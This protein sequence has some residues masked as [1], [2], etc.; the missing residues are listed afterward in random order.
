MEQETFYRLR[1]QDKII[2]QMRVKAEQVFFSKDGFWWRGDEQLH[3]QVKKGL[4]TMDDFS[5]LKDKNNRMLFAED[6]VQFKLG[7]LIKKKRTFRLSKVADEIQV[8]PLF[9]GPQYQLHEVALKPDL[10]WV[11]YAFLQGDISHWGS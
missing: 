10:E 1:N 8:L 9:P 3:A 6:I 11:S 2:A 5:G 4:F 7:T